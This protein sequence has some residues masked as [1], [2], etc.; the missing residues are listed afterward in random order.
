VQVSRDQREGNTGSE[1]A[2]QDLE[3]LHVA[4][5]LPLVRDAT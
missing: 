5:K 4:L 3:D 2:E 1:Q